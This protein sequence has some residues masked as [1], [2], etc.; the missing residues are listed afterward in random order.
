[1]KLFVQARATAI[2]TKREG[3][4]VVVVES[5]FADTPVAILQDAEIGSRAYINE[6]TGRFLD[7]KH[8]ARDLTDF[9]RA[10]DSF[11]PRQ[12]A[13]QNISCYCSSQILNDALK[14]QALKCGQEWTQDLAPMQ[15]SPDPTLVRP[16][17]RQR[18]ASERDEIHHRFGLEIGL[19]LRTQCCQLL[20]GGTELKA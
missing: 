1:M 8:L 17:D 12:W 16:E 14:E 3:S 9:T 5:M 19:P 2:L 7:G 10:A 11:H 18:L 15:W 13:E 20:S 4:C 6:H